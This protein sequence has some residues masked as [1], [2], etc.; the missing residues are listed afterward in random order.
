MTIPFLAYT[1][2]SIIEFAIRDFS[3]LIYPLTFG[4]FMS[5]TL[6]VFVE[7]FYYDWFYKEEEIKDEK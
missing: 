7:V 4:L 1:L 6:L 2:H 5:G 3:L